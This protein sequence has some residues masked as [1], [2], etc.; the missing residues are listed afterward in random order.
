MLEVNFEDLKR[1]IQHPFKIKDGKP[2]LVTVS[3][4]SFTNEE[5]QV[6]KGYRKTYQDCT[7]EVFRVFRNL[8]LEKAE[9]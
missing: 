8:L 9:V 4:G 2:E 1:K 3:V 7:R 5:T 6:F